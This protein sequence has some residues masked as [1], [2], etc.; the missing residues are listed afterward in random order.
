MGAAAFRRTLLALGLLLAPALPAR[1]A[2]A[3]EAD[4]YGLGSRATALGGAVAADTSDFSATY[5]NPAGLTGATGLSLSLGYVYAWNHLRMNGLDSGVANV[6]GLVGG[7]V[8]PGKVAGIPFAF[9]LGTYLPDNGLSQVDALQQQ[10]PRWALYDGRAS[11]LFLTASLA[12]KPLPFLEIG[13]GLTFLAATTGSFSISGTANLLNPYESQLR[14]QVDADLTAIRYPSAGV[15]LRTGD[16]GYLAFAYRGQ[17]KLQLDITANLNGLVDFAGINVPLTYDLT[18]M[19]VNAFLP[20][21]VVIGASFQKIEHLHVNFDLTWVNWSA[22]VSPTAVTA[23]TLTVT[24]PPGIPLNLPAATKPV[25]IVPPDFE[26]RWVPRIG[27]EY[28]LPA[29]GSMR[30]VAGEEGMRRAVEIPL[31]AGYVYERSPVPPQT[32]LT[33]FVDT[34]R[35]TIS[36]G[37]GVILNA[38]GK[39]LAG[40]LRLDVHA[41][42]SVL[43]T[44]VTEKASAADFIGDYTA[45]GSMFG[46]GTTLSAVF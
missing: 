43:P 22:F 2:L 33:N 13:G 31:R 35:H 5:Y 24:P 26:D 23:A 7:L 18:S 27:V 10:T 16:L 6:H 20:Q 19:T 15:R 17:T 11:I 21:Q 34:D 32:G 28:V 25:A 46:L 45:D 40:S 4:T 14:H 9:A 30:K 41:Q 1:E 37:T 3:N 29:A 38:P 12:V 36:V 8:A 39:E 44:R 42:W